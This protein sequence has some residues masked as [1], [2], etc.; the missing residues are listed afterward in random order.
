MPRPPFFQRFRT[1][2][3]LLVFLLVV[4]AFGLVLYSN[5]VQRHIQ[6]AAIEDGAEGLSG[7]AAANE[8]DIIRNAR[9]L[10][11]T[12]TQFDF[13][14]LGTNRQFCEYS[15]R[16]LLKLSP[17][18]V[19]FGLIETNGALFCSG[20]TTN[21]SANLFDCSYFQK[22][23]RS[24]KFS[25]GDFQVGGLTR[26]PSLIVAYPAF[27]QHGVLERVI[28]AS[29]KLSRFSEAISHIQLPQG[30]TILVLDRNGRILA[31]EPSVQVGIGAP[32][33]TNQ[34]VKRILAGTTRVFTT[35]GIDSVRRLHAVTPI[36]DGQRNSLFV[37]VSVPVS[38][39]MA[40]VNQALVR[41]LLVL[42]LVAVMVTAGFWLYAQ[43][44]FLRP[45]AS[46]VNAANELAVGNFAART[47]PIRG[48]AELIALGE[49]F[50]DMA[51]NLE[52]R[53]AELLKV[54]ETLKAEITERKQVEQRLR[55]HAAEKQKLEEQFFRSQRMESL[56]ALAGGIA[57]DLNN[58]LAPILIG[59]ELLQQSPYADPDRSAV[60]QLIT[61]SARRCT[62]MVKQIVNF[63]KGSRTQSESIQIQ[64]AIAEMAKII[65][66]TFPKSISIR[67]R[68]AS[69]LFTIPG[70]PTELHQVLMNFCVNARDAM[71]GGG[72]LTL[73]A[74]NHTMSAAEAKQHPNARPGNYVLLAVTDTGMGMSAKTIQRIFEPF[75]TTKTPDK[76]T[77][78]GLS[79][80]A[81]IVKKYDGFLQVQSKL[82]KGTTFKVFLPATA[83]VSNSHAASPQSR[84][85]PI[86]HRELILVVEDERT[87]LELAKTTLENY[88]YQVL[89]ARN[90]LEAVAFFEAR[91]S[92]IRLLITDSDMP[93]LNGPEAVEKIHNLRPGLPVI[94]ASG[95]HR[96]HEALG[97]I[98]PALLTKLSKPYGV[99]Q[100]LEVVNRVLMGSADGSERGRFRTESA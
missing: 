49:T 50:D 26:V 6:T 91:K 9:Q 15:F 71:P 22:V 5:L 78:L 56:G 84:K 25:V 75:F 96:D 24:G 3:S 37:C 53:Q 73:V 7:L 80:V 29:L 51:Q 64:D 18:Y 34:V 95:M 46:L 13:L 48:A 17:D 57:H 32:L 41:N 12:L 87:L 77:G 10:L 90:G 19:N 31:N 33:A 55:E 35:S 2:L 63:A 67:S 60:V 47:A 70:D 86:G 93:F 68:V 54:N 8:E 59:S 81:H 65:G 28:F 38:V 11:G 4:P 82:G 61:S 20:A 97:R 42:V 40:Q 44:F 69:G 43:K 98:K 45:V 30:G 88:G 100:L 72:E 66:D 1:R 21:A 52:S 74:Q 23:I 39:S 85:L 27:D 94:M 62:G 99:E 92:E 14:V 79:T 36:S 89:T 76:G 16:N 83:T 58:A